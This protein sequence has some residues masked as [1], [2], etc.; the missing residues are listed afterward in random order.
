[1][2]RVRWIVFWSQ[3][4]Y[5]KI[6]VI[7]KLC[8][9]NTLSWFCFRSIWAINVGNLAGKTP[10]K[11]FSGPQAVPFMHG[12]VIQG[13]CRNR[14]LSKA[15]NDLTIVF[16]VKGLE[17]EASIFVQILHCS[18]QKILPAWALQN[19]HHFCPLITS[20]WLKLR[21]SS[22]VPLVVRAVKSV[23]MT[24]IK[25]YKRESQYRGKCLKH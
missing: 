23:E 16:R 10:L 22:W 1:M 18:T 15:N 9:D 24:G 8:S 5:F 11:V 20:L 4:N 19:N 2:K 7:Q 3:T 14:S 17:E 13:G 25:V 12:F 6:M 21:W